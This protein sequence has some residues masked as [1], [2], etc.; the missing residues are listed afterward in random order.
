MDLNISHWVDAR[1]AILT[2]PS[3]WQPNAGRALARLKAR[4]V[5]RLRFMWASALAF[6]SVCVCFLLLL[7]QPA[8]ASPVCAPFQKHAN[9]LAAATSPAEQNFKESGPTNAPVT[10]EIYSDYECPM[11]ASY[12]RD[13]MPL[14]V[15]HYVQ[16]GKIKLI[17][18]DFP[19]PQHTH[20]RLATRYA[21]AAGRL[22]YYDI[23]AAQIF[24]TQDLW[25]KNGEIEIQVAQVLPPGLMQKVRQMANSDS[26]LDDTVTADVA[27]G[28]QD[29]VGG[30]PTVVI[31]AH[32]KR[33]ILPS[34]PSFNM[35]K[36]Y[37]DQLL[38]AR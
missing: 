29:H 12:A 24:K 25:N 1:M 23:V 26:S 36:V 28:R 21:N 11:C 9:F 22:G 7:A 31:V 8:C 14:V 16:T 18:R 5:R 30:T 27:M 33:Q 6:A 13:V 37:L 10:F 20:S 3:Y 4:K 38:T 17:H 35:L 15:A 19:L 34:M 32:G 2:P